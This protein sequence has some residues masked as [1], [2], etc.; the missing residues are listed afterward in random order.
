MKKKFVTVLL[1]IFIGITGLGIW[2][3]N[4]FLGDDP[5]VREQLHNQFGED[6]FSFDID[7]LESSNL[8][9]N[10]TS[11]NPQTEYIPESVNPVQAPKNTDQSPDP[12]H[13][14]E[15]KPEKNNDG[16]VE[17]K[18]KKS[19]TMD[20]I[21]IKYESKFMLLQDVGLSRLDLLVS[22]ATQEYKEGKESGS[23]N[24]SELAKKYLQAGTTLEK[25]M[26]NQFYSLLSQM[27]G[28]LK[29]NNLPTDLVKT[30]EEI[31]EN[32]KSSKRAELFAKIQ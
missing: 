6:F 12:N 8:A 31:Y 24:R 27:E 22:T 19:L 20:E 11:T 10:I 25:N 7:V 13:S 29:E 1:C 21:N 3:Y 30:Y 32:A 14:R 28:E 18:G 15:A 5:V 26:D 4:H 23:L 9:E 2:G 16:L 17:D